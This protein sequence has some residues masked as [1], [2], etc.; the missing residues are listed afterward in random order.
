[1]NQEVIRISPSKARL[2]PNIRTISGLDDGAIQD[3]ADSLLRIGQKTPCRGYVADDDVVEIWDG[4]RRYLAAKRAGVDLDIL[5]A[6]RPTYLGAAQL[7]TFD[8]EGISQY[9]RVAAAAEIFTRELKP[10]GLTQEQAARELDMT[11]SY[12]SR[13]LKLARCVD[14]MDVWR[15]HPDLPRECFLAA[16][17][18]GKKDKAAR[19]AALRPLLPSHAMDAWTQVYGPAPD[20]GGA[21]AGS[22]GG[23]GAGA[24]GARKRPKQ[25]LRDLDE[26]V[27]QLATWTEDIERPDQTWL[28]Y[29]YAMGARDA[30]RY[31]S[32]TGG[33]PTCFPAPGEEHETAP[34]D[35]SESGPK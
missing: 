26:Q 3:L 7:G 21:G 8:Y 22:G 16:A 9:E 32:N 27:A 14:L 30:L 13:T 34:G 18:A 24:A 31:V 20:N 19:G 6:P 11:Q 35:D 5:I 25:L 4:Q 1:M 29:A 2:A 15:Q 33:V 28:D 10:A 12:L 23:A 17:A